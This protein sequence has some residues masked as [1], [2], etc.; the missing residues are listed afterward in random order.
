MLC[1]YDSCCFYLRDKG[2]QKRYTITL[3]KG[4]S[5]NCFDATFLLFIIGMPLLNYPGAYGRKQVSRL[6]MEM[7]DDLAYECM[8]KD[9]EQ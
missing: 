3:Q 5:G 8:S 9:D 7:L 1:N 6:Y 4:R 2:N